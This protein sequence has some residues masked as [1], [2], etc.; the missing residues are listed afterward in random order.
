MSSE[1][2]TLPMTWYSAGRISILQN[3]CL[4]FCDRKRAPQAESFC[5]AILTKKWYSL[6]PCLDLERYPILTKGYFSESQCCDLQNRYSAET[7]HIPQA[8]IR[9]SQKLVFCIEFDQILV[10]L[11]QCPATTDRPNDLVFC[12]THQYSPEHLFVHL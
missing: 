2:L 3:T 10:M 11:D 8:K 7:Q 5:D 9:R 6:T 1:T 4:F 12:W